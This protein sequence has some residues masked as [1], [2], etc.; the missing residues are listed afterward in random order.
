MKCHESRNASLM[1]DSGCD[2]LGHV[3]KL[4]YKQSDLVAFGPILRRDT[5][6]NVTEG[7]LFE[8]LAGDGRTLFFDLI[9]FVLHHEAMSK[10]RKT[11]IVG[12]VP[13]EHTERTKSHEQA[14][15]FSTSVRKA[16]FSFLRVYPLCCG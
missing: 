6:N 3:P 8:R 12:W 7:P 15:Y 13:V 4:P 14:S 5:L 11:C 2:G 9:K 10:P 16:S 1:W